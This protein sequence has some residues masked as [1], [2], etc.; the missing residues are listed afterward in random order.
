MKKTTGKQAAKPAATVAPEKKFNY[1]YL[2][3]GIVILTFLLYTNCLNN[4]LLN[5]DDYDYFNLTPEVRDLS[6]ATVKKIFS[7]Y[8]LIMYQPLPVL[9]F[10]INYHFSEFN[11]WWPY[12]LPNILM[13]LC[14]IVLVF[15]FIKQLTTK[16]NIAIIVALL[17]AIHPMN[18]EAVSWM[19]ARSSSMYTLFYLLALM[20]YV[21]YVKGNNM[22][23][24]LFT[25]LFFILSLL[26]KAQAVTLPVVLF[27]IDYYYARKINAKM[28]LEKIP[29]F[30]LSI[31]F[32]I[33]TIMNPET[34]N[35][36]TNGM[37]I[38]Y[39]AVDM[40][41]MVCYS[42]AFYFFKL[43]LPVKLCAV[44][45]YPPKHGGMLPWEYYVSPVFMM[46]LV[47]LAYRFRK[48]RTVIFSLALFFIT[49][50][51]N[52]QIIPSRLFIVTDRYGYF[53]YIGLFLIIGYV[54]NN[55]RESGNE[56]LRGYSTRMVSIIGIF[57]LAFAWIVVDRNK[58]WAND[59]V[60]MTDI[61]EK[62][63]GVPYLVRA[64]GNRGNYYLRNGMIPQAIEDFTSALKVA[65]TDA[66][67]Y[68]NRGNCYRQAG[69]LNE[70]LNDLDSA[71]KYQ[72]DIALIY[73][74]MAYIKFMMKDYNG[75]LEAA[76]TCIKL[77]KTIPE[78]FNTR[79]AVEFTTGDYV[80]C[81]RDLNESLKLNPNYT[82]AYKNRGLLYIRTNRKEQ[83]CTDF[84]KAL[85]LG[86]PEAQGLLN[87]NCK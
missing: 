58:A 9:T 33:I 61:I 77:N 84:Q 25:A 56:K 34:K 48:N 73:S 38:S 67:T 42:F 43:I 50:L 52:I 62:N 24:L 74:D 85:M 80:A 75:A 63:E 70:A 87:A 8:Y 15:Q 11:S 20:Q 32:G 39:N 4:E 64:Y 47:Y 55:W 16:E 76:N 57:C 35:N 19:S 53:P 68:Y 54:Y 72:P 45:I 7:S 60:F 83:A 41:F 31:L 78:V 79:A 51:L 6:W 30:A 37:M 81:E 2:L 36:I 66:Q 49:I 26:T 17:F 71:K 28:V 59:E 5:F 46:A 27:A 65:P 86:S 18:V 12:H 23:H 1:Y 3:G 10:A 22:K 21:Q 40:F 69:R 44:Y 82:D 13:H 14:N 29:F